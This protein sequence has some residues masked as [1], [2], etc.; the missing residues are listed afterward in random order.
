LAK[1]FLESTAKFPEFIREARLEGQQDQS[2][3]VIQSERNKE[4]TGVTLLDLNRKALRTFE[5]EVSDSNNQTA[6]E[7]RAF[8]AG[9]VLLPSEERAAETLRTLGLTLTEIK[10]PLE[11]KVQSYM[12]VSDRLSP[13]PFEGFFERI[14]QAETRDT[15]VLIPPGA[16]WIDSHQQRFHMTKELLE[17]EGTNGFVRYRVIDPL[18]DQPFPVYRILPED[19]IHP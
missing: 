1:S 13:K 9:Y 16:W 7:T 18:L 15:I 6:T 11:A 12:L 17:P 8:P 10:E 3:V 5:E 19:I 14:V 2:P 4:M